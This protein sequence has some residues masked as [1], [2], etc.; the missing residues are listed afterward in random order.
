MK[1]SDILNQKRNTIR[2]IAQRYRVTNPRVFGSVLHGTDNDG[3]DL[4]LLI[5]ALPGTTLFDL[6]G[7][8]NRVRRRSWGS[9]GYINTSRP[10]V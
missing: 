1:P 6:G 9:R 7:V 4:D 5:D 2:Q 10:T 8:T 3:S